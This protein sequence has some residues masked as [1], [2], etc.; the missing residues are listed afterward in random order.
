MTFQRVKIVL[1]WSKGQA[2]GHPKY[3]NMESVCYKAGRVKP[4]PG[5]SQNCKTWDV[6]VLAD[7]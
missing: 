2:R 4:R 7:R 6:R 5:E 3:Q 1:G